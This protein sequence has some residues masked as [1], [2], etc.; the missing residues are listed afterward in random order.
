[1][2]ASLHREELAV[3]GYRRDVLHIA[4]HTGDLHRN[5]EV[6]AVMWT[7]RAIQAGER[8]AGRYHRGDDSTQLVLSRNSGPERKRL[9]DVGRILVERRHRRPRQ[10]VGQTNTRHTGL[11]PQ[12]TQRFARRQRQSCRR[13]VIVRQQRLLRCRQIARR[14]CRRLALRR[15]EVV[16]GGKYLRPD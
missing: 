2:C 11:G 8:K 9:E 4:A 14:P 16:L 3:A 12:M 7:D 15:V 1:M 5:V 13:L 6:L 10:R